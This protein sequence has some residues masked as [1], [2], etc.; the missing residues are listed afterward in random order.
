MITLE[1]LRARPGESIPYKVRLVYRYLEQQIAGFQKMTGP[2]LLRDIT[3][4]GFYFRAIPSEGDPFI[5]SLRV[6]VSGLEASVGLGSV[7]DLEPTINGVKIKDASNPKV[8]IA[9][10]PD[11][12]LRSWV[13]VE[14]HFEGGVLR[15]DEPL[16]VVHRNTL[17]VEAPDLV[18]VLPLALLQWRDEASIARVW[19]IVHFDQK[20]VLRAAVGGRKGRV[21]FYPAA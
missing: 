7:D 11:S 17:A 3:G 19:Q 15:A 6:S 16:P 18:G 13:C 4:D 21:V 14:A 2:G 10:G 1:E 12:D 20:T 8:K 5:G 9:G